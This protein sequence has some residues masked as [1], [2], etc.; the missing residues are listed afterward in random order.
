MTLAGA[1]GLAGR[2]DDGVSLIVAD[3]ETDETLGL[4]FL[5]VRPQAGVVG[6]AYWVAPHARGRGIGTRAVRLAA[7]W[8]LARPGTVR[9]EAWVSPANVASQRLLTAAGFTHE[10]RLRSFTDFGDRR[11]D[12]IVFSRVALRIFLAGA[13]G[14]LGLRIVPL[15]VAQHHA[16][17]AMTR[18]PGKADGLARLGAEPVVCDVYEEPALREAVSEFRADVVMHQV[19]DLP[20]DRAQLRGSGARNDRIRTEGT[21]NLVAAAAGRPL[22]AQSIAWELPPHRAGTIAEHERMVLDA[23]GVVLRYGQLYGPG[24]YYAQPPPPPR[25]SVD[26]A[27]RRTVALLGVA[28]GIY[29]L[30][31]DG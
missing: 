30:V 4:V 6:M 8:A 29:D 14:V 12:V 21:R 17:A 28:P 15:L 18:T 24:T 1:L 10:G 3:A 16:V 7:D 19:T 5:P 26:Q 25:I 27:A 31:E 22:Y 13:S 9:V 2:P 11:S 20:D 23:G